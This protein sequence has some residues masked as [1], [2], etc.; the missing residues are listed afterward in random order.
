[1]SQE[2]KQYTKEDFLQTLEPYEFVYSFKESGFT[3]EKILTMV[4]DMA[5]KQGIR[6]FK[7]LFQEFVK[8]KNKESNVLSCASVTQFEGQ[9]LELNAGNWRCTEFGVVTDGMFGEVEAC[10]HPIL[11]SERLKNIDTGIEKLKVHF[12]KG[13]TWTFIIDERLT[14]ASSTGIVKLANCGISVN[15]ENSKYL[16]KYLHDLE[17]LNYEQIPERSSVARMGW[18]NESDFVPY[19]GSLEFDGDENLKKCFSAVRAKGSFDKWLDIAKKARNKSIATKIILAASFASIL[20]K[21]FTL[22]PFFV[23]LWGGTEVG[24]T[25]GLMLAASVW[26]DPQLGVYIQ[27]FNSTP[28]GR[29]RLAATFNSLPLIL[30]ELQV[31]KDKKT[32]DSDIYNLCE[33]SG[34]LRGNKIGGTEQTPTWANCILSSGEMPI[35]NIGSGG[36]AVNRIVEIECKDKL[37]DDPQNVCNVLKKNFGHAGQK[38]VEYLQTDGVL[39]KVYELYKLNYN[40]LSENDTTEKQ[41]IAGALILTADKVINTL[42]FKD[43]VLTSDDIKCF[44]HTKKAVSSN[45]R[46]Y[47]FL[48]GWVTQNQNKFI[49]KLNNNEDILRMSEILGEIDGDY[50]YLNINKFNEICEEGGFNE[51]SLLSFLK[52]RKVIMHSEKRNTISHRINKIP[53]CCLCFRLRNEGEIDCPF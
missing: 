11:I 19:C 36:G 6:N 24:K 18:I 34:K 47:E 23:H 2:L 25:V 22:Q 12:K 10:S 38:F 7:K 44:L 3:Q 46:G 15:S 42:L 45:E 20:L 50:V 39:E 52:D 28:V 9:P 37:F 1:M 8:S 17:T 40:T 43:K 5:Q 4:A 49:K 27:N 53:T 29:E 30:D 14:F 31:I 16:V 33:G 35:T 41:A 26:A 13:R 51:S 32:F 48:C 21:R